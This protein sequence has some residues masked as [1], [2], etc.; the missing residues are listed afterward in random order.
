MYGDEEVAVADAV[1]QE[2]IG[3]LVVTDNAQTMF[4]LLQ[5]LSNVPGY[6]NSAAGREVIA[7]V[8]RMEYEIAAPGLALDAIATPKLQTRRRPRS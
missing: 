4:E 3:K 7:L 5:R 8:R 6:K 1:V 2:S